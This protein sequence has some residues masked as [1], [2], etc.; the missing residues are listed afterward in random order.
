[1]YLVLFL[2]GQFTFPYSSQSHS[3]KTQ[4][5]SRM[6]FLLEAIGENSSSAFR[7]SIILDK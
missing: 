7:V 4:G 6:V 5:V 2:V 3:P 1:M